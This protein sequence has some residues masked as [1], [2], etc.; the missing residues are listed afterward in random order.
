MRK[1]RKRNKNDVNDM[2]ALHSVQCQASLG[3][4]TGIIKQ[5]TTCGRPYRGLKF[6]TAYGETVMNHRA[7]TRLQDYVVH[8][9][10]GFT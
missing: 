9:N 4:N 1:N 5:R 3:P 7:E 8:K 10:E 2:A 6:Q